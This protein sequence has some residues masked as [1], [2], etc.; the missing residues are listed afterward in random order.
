MLRKRT[1]FFSFT[2]PPPTLFKFVLRSYCTYEVELGATDVF[3][4]REKVIN[5]NIIR[6]IFS[7]KYLGLAII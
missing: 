5:F 6:F 1:E 3:G 2:G 4:L 7:I